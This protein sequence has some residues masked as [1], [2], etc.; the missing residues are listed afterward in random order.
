MRDGGRGVALLFFK[1]WILCWMALAIIIVRH[2]YTWDRKTPFITGSLMEELLLFSLL[3]GVYA[4]LSAWWQATAEHN[5]W[6]ELGPLQAIGWLTGHALYLLIV[7]GF[8]TGVLLGMLFAL[9]AI[10]HRYDRTIGIQPM[11]VYPLP[12]GSI[13]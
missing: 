6:K 1:F 2:T 5:P 3:L 13:H 10:I 9:D 7:I 4:S 8:Y 11:T 12:Q